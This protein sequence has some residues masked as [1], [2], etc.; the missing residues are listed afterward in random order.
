MGRR[1]VLGGSLLLVVS[2]CSSSTPTG[3]T[4]GSGSEAI[5]NGTDST[6]AQNSVVMIEQPLSASSVVICSG[7]LLAPTLVMTARHC[8]SNLPDEG[9]TCDENGVGSEGGDILSD[10]DPTSLYIFTGATRE[11]KLTQARAR[12]TKLFHDTATNICNHDLALI[13]LDTAIDDEPIV[14]VRLK[15]GPTTNESVVAVGW[16]VTTSTETPSTRQQRTLDIERVGPNRDDANEL[17]V[18]PNEFEVGESICEGDSGGPAFDSTTGA[19]VGIVSRGG[20]DTQP[21]AGDPA[22]SCVGASNFYSEPSH[23]ESIIDSAYAAAGQDPWL[24]GQ[25]DPRLTAPGDSCTDSAACQTGLCGDVNGSRICTYDCSSAACP[26]G[27][28]CEASDAGGSFCIASAASSSGGSSGGCAVSG[29]RDRDGRGGSN[30]G[31]LGVGLGLA[32]LATRRA[33][34]RRH[35]R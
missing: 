21:V 10:V 26:S 15:T 13:L 18:P 31:F 28:A 8:V 32:A 24:E 3:E 9:F 35:R 4:T 14:P 22:A 27:F 2:A 34:S 16:G 6:D 17:D 7:V 30:I 12:G 19:V 5:I 33:R 11:T 29:G 25:G 20:N 23:F 1:W